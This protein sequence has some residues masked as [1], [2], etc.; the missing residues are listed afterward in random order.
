MAPATATAPIAFLI[1]RRNIAQF[2]LKQMKQTLGSAMRAQRTT[3]A[4]LRFGAVRQH[5]NVGIA[6]R[7]LQA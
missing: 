7:A 2:S 6:G 1:V 5:K 4:A 3:E